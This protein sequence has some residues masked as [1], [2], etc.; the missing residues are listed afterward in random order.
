MKLDSALDDMI[1]SGRG[2][3]GKGGGKGQNKKQGAKNAG[4]N[5]APK[6]KKPAFEKKTQAEKKGPGKKAPMDV[7]K[8]LDM[9]LEDIVKMKSKKAPKA[10]GNAGAQ[11]GAG[12]KTKKLGKFAAKVNRR[13]ENNGKGQGKKQWSKG[14]QKGKWGGNKGSQKGW[15]KGGRKGGG[16]RWEEEWVPA[17]RQNKGKG[18][19]RDSWSNER[20]WGGKGDYGRKG[21]G[22][23]KYT[24]RVQDWEPPARREFTE[25]RVSD[26]VPKGAGR[27]RA[28]WEDV[29]VRTSRP[30]PLG[31]DW[32][33]RGGAARRSTDEEG[34]SRTGRK[35]KVT[36]IPRDLDMRDIK[37]AFEAEAGKIASC[38]MERGT[39]WIVFTNPKDAMKAVDT[40]D[41]GELNGKTI[42]VVF[43][44]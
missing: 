20:E 42:T 2:K 6:V 30:Q 7:G 38:T 21:K 31:R 43:D 1:K 32:A 25:R 36:N 27:A 16:K 40:F 28:E 44:R 14:Q 9:S 39:A 24:E 4:G 13:A 33:V 18:K 37:D 15:Q 22:G 17:R 35:I 34:P 5:N 41:R 3:K 29:G 10:G 11:K 19:G 26:Y 12:P 23:G 8:V